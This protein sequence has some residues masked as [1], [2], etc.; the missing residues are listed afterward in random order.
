MDRGILYRGEILPGSGFCRI[1]PDLWETEN[2]P[3]DVRARRPGAVSTQF[4]WHWTAGHCLTG[5][6]TGATV[7]RRMDQRERPDGSDMSVSVP[8]VMGWDGLI[9]QTADLDLECCHAG[10]RFNRAGPACEITWPGT[11]KQGK[12]LGY[13]FA[14]ERRLIPGKGGVWCMPPSPEVLESARQLW[15][16]LSSLDLPGLRIRVS[17]EHW[18]APGTTKIDAAGYINGAV[19]P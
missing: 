13:D 4:T 7:K 2:E 6:R 5:E 8:F 10:R 9:F 18:Q 19:Q 17:R 12:A 11:A 14:A 1:V 3:N 16:F 15:A